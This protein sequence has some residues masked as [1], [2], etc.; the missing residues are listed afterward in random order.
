MSTGL[1]GAQPQPT[2][3]I[4]AKPEHE[5]I[6]DALRELNGAIHRLKELH[7]DILG[8]DLPVQDDGA[9]NTP[10]YAALKTTLKETPMRIFQSVEQINCITAEIRQTLFTP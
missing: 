8:E 10:S 1:S 2:A 6:Q 9:K 3:Q 5:Q 4:G 7:L